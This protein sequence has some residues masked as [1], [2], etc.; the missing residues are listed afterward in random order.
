MVSRACQRQQEEDAVDILCDRRDAR[1]A[2]AF[3]FK[4]VFGAVK[5]GLFA[6]AFPVDPLA[7]GGGLS[8]RVAQGRE[9]D[10]DF[11]ARE[12]HAHQAD[13]DL[14]RQLLLGDEGARSNASAN[15][16]RCASRRARNTRPGHSPPPRVDWFAP[17]ISRAFP[18]CRAKS[19]TS[20]RWRASDVRANVGLRRRVPRVDKIR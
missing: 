14:R 4:D 7:F 9:Q 2:E 5:V 20:H 18:A 16:G 11:A 15:P 3:D 10:F 12:Q 1:A 19:E 8:L 13:A 6:P 17:Y